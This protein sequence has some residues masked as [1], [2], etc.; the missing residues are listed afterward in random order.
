MFRKKSVTSLV[1]KTQSSKAFTF[2]KHD[3]QID[4]ALNNYSNYIIIFTRTFDNF[5]VVSF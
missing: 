5:L 2:S 3:Q 1:N 4:K